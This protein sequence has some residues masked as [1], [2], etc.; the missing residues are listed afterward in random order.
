MQAQAQRGHSF[1]QDYRNSSRAPPLLPSDIEMAK[2]MAGGQAGPPAPPRTPP[3]GPPPST[4][5]PT[6]PTAQ[7]VAP[8][9]Q[10]GL[11]PVKGP[12]ADLFSDPADL[13]GGS[14]GDPLAAMR[15]E[16]DNMP[17]QD[18]QG[19]TGHTNP[20]IAG[21]AK[22]YLKD[23]AKSRYSTVQN[24]L[25]MGG[26]GRVDQYGALSGYQGPQK[27]ITRDLSMAG[28][29]IQNEEYDP[30]KKTWKAVGAPY[31]R[32]G[33]GMTVYGRDGN[34]IMSTGDGG[35]D[36]PFARGL[37]KDIMSDQEALD[38]MNYVT[39]LYEPEFLSYGG[40]GKAAWDTFL[41]KLDPEN[42]SQFTA[43]RSAFVSQAN[44][45]FIAY[46]KWATGVA[47]GEKEMAEI[48]RS[49]YSEDD[50]P[51]DFEAKIAGMKQMTKKLMV[52]KAMAL[53]SGIEVGSKA[54]KGFV[55]AT[56][57]DGIPD[58]QQRGDA[59][60]NLGYSEAQVLGILQ[61]EGYK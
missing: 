24:P 25:G 13:A 53:K 19:L 57:L 23:K 56:S 11:P 18:V 58:L 21:M 15:H 41:N 20:M 34:P 3:V 2:G 29:M 38:S 47:G 50:S 14:A 55:A 49:T 36:K 48:K 30:V 9:Q 32:R 60:A 52:R 12:P 8:V 45:A 28:G 35:G 51:Q 43:R 31:S 39:S 54:W 10:G 61:Q 22:E 37:K 27:P 33:K 42:R 4:S 16:F 26:T 6:A 7:P 1:P 59:L 5:M 44:Q 17:I 46:R 40:Q